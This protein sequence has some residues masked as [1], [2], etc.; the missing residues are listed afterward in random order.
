MNGNKHVFFQVA[1]GRDISQRE[2][3]GAYLTRTLRYGIAGRCVLALLT[4]ALVFF[5]VAGWQ[6]GLAA[7]D[8]AGAWF[9]AIC[10]ALLT[11]AGL[12]VST[13]YWLARA[14]FDSSRQAGELRFTLDQGGI[15]CSWPEGESRLVPSAFQSY[16]ETDR[17][18]FLHSKHGIFTFHKRLLSEADMQCLREIL[19]GWGGPA[20]PDDRG[21]KPAVNNPTGHGVSAGHS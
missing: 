10:V 15:H 9:E 11:V 14:R 4:A 6:R 12:V 1:Y 2:F 21:R 7:E 13:L 19:N 3:V 20:I 18:L 8:P 17:Y 16:R 5:I